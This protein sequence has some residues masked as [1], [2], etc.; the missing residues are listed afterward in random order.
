MARVSRPNR[1]T[2]EQRAEI[3]RRW[4][5]GQSLSDIGRALGKIPGSVY[6]VV[7]A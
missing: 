1:T 6:H 4:K 3:W 7:K 2:S 5:D